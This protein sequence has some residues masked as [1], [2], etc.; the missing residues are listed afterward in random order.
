[1]RCPAHALDATLSLLDDLAEGRRGQVG[2]PDGLEA[3]P[4]ALDRVEF[5]RAASDG[6]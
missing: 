5:R 1:V 4:Q 3:R 6:E 2:Q